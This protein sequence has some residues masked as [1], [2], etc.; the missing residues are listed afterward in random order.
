LRPKTTIAGHNGSVGTVLAYAYVSFADAGANG[1]DAAFERDSSELRETCARSA[2]FAPGK[3]TT[4]KALHMQRPLALIVMT[5]RRV[6]Q[7]T[8]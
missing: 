3:M 7:F 5:S 6:A 2:A 1:E 8:P 4:A